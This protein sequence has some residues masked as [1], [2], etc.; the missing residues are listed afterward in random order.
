MISTRL[1]VAPTDE[2]V[3]GTRRGPRTDSRMQ[4]QSLLAYLKSHLAFH[5]VEPLVLIEVQVQ[6]RTAGKQMRM[7]HNE[8]AAAGFARGDLDGKRAR[9]HPERMPE[10]VFTIANNVQSSGSWRR[11]SIGRA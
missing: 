3:C 10:A 8:K 7:L 2:N 1:G 6:R 4:V 11:R 5:H 9:G